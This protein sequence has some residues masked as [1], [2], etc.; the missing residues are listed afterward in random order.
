V[1]KTEGDLACVCVR[2][3]SDTPCSSYCGCRYY[4]CSEECKK[5]FERTPGKYLKR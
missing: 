5:S 3:R 1:C 2:I 4:F